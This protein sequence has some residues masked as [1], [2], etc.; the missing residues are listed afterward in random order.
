MTPDYSLLG[1]GV[2][3]CVAGIWERFTD[4]RKRRENLQWID[5]AVRTE[6]VI[7]RVSERKDYSGHRDTYDNIATLAVPIVRFRAADGHDY[8][9]DGPNGLG[10]VGAK[11]SVAYNPDL[12]SDARAIATTGYR[13]G[14]GFILIAI[15]LALAAK[16]MFA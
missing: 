8:E 5:S 12:P 14:C 16:A 1:V 6:G 7:S 15:G 10:E 4:K 9:F 2:L 3:L 11:V 13:G